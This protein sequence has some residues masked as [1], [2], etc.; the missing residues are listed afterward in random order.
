MNDKKSVFRPYTQKAC[1]VRRSV[2]GDAICIDE[3]AVSRPDRIQ[4]LA[5]YVSAA[6]AAARLGNLGT[7]L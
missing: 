5:R 3:H 2:P 6:L 1:D 4:F 7:G